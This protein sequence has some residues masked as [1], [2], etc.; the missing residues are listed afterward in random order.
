[1]VTPL[2]VHGVDISHHQDGTLD[3]A[4]AKAHGLLWLYHK[5]S[6]GNTFRDDN[7]GARRAQA[8]AAGL[9]F[10]AYHFARVAVGNAASQAEFFLSVAQPG[11]KDLRPALDLETTEGLTLT[12]LRTWTKAF[13][14]AVENVAR[15]KPI[16]YT[17]FDLGAAADGCIIWRARYNDSNT[18]PALPFDIW[19]FSNG[20]LGIPD[21]MFGIGH[22]DLNTMRAGL[23]L[24][25][26]LINNQEDDMITDEE[27]A[28]IRAIV[29]AEAATAAAGGAQSVLDNFGEKAK[30]ANPFPLLTGDINMDTLAGALITRTGA[31]KD[32][33]VDVD[34]IKDLTVERIAEA[35]AARITTDL[36]VD[37]DPAVIRAEV[38]AGVRDVFAELAAP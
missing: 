18:P 8:A 26:M 34:G 7:Y 30:L 17:P 12:E 11:P 25:D 2:V 19:Q 27:F 35:V 24:G 16:I 10:G 9:P 14:A 4:G 5:A 33:A 1:M 31:I 15:A 37:I 21:S 3:L 13:I 38:V 36:T 20:V 23:T 6:E 28:K 22:V 32:I 29:R